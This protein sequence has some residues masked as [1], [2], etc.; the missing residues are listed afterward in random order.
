MTLP[1]L[2]RQTGRWPLLAV[3]V[4]VAAAAAAALLQIQW[5][6]DR[7]CRGSLSDPV[8]WARTPHGRRRRRQWRVL[9]CPAAIHPSCLSRCREESNFRCWSSTFDSWTSHFV[10]SRAMVKISCQASMFQN[11]RI[12]IQLPWLSINR[13]SYKKNSSLQILLEFHL[14]HR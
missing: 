12:A 3:A 6:V 10:N 1:G 11:V 14:F 8:M 13:L 4:A 5:A 9:L 2:M 7:C